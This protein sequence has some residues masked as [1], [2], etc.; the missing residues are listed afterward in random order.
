MNG[1]LTRFSGLSGKQMGEDTSNTSSLDLPTNSSGHI[2]PC[3]SQF[4][5][6]PTRPNRTTISSL[7]HSRVSKTFLLFPNSSSFTQVKDE[8]KLER[9][10]GTTWSQKKRG[11][12]SRRKSRRG[13]CEQLVLGLS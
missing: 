6:S 7:R 8:V 4:L 5:L 11:R 10:N 1:A 13:K 9:N 2:Q 12:I 3:W